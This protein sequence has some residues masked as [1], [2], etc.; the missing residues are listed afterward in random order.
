M[1]AVTRTSV[2]G[3]RS[4]TP[5]TAST[6]T[7]S[8]ATSTGARRAASNGRVVREWELVAVDKEIEVMPG[9]KF[10]AW[11]Y[12]GRI[13]GPTLR[14]ARASGCG[15]A[16]PTAPST[17][18]RSTS[19]ASTPPSMD[20]V[21]GLGAGQI[22]PGGVDRL[23]V[24]RAAGRAAPLPLPRAPAGRAHRQGAL[25]RVH[26]R[27]GRAARGGGRARDGH[28]RVRHEL[29][30]RQRGLRGQLDRLRLHGPA[31]PGQA[32]RA[33]AGLHRQ[34]ARVRPDQLVPPAREP[35]R[36]LPD[37]D[38]EDPVGADRHGDALPGPARDRSSGASRTPASTCSTRT[39]PSSRSSAG[40]A[41]SRSRDG[42][43]DASGTRPGVGARARPAAAGRRRA[44]GCSRR[45]TRPAWASGAGRR[46]RSWRSSGPCSRRARSR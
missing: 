35:V 34:R 12:N 28:E 39:S 32:Q 33:R 25:R 16:S 24:R 14:A 13:P 37:G 23:R 10:A 17:R 2:A 44:S 15:S 29:R 1:T 3:S 18:T 20:G 31:D 45:S 42:C 27:P 4:T 30:P 36:L 5:P 9:V 46:P 8:C 11:T 22:E 6:R 21:P 40:R 38:V 41:S 19:T 26:H 7:R 43:G